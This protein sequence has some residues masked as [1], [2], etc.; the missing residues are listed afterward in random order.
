MAVTSRL[1]KLCRLSVDKRARPSQQ[2][3]VRGSWDRARL[4]ELQQA[5]SE[6]VWELSSRKIRPAGRCL[7]RCCKPHRIVAFIECLSLIASRLCLVV[8]SRDLML[9][10]ASRDQWPISWLRLAG[11]T[12][13][14]PTYESRAS[15]IIIY[16]PTMS[17]KSQRRP[18]ALTANNIHIASL[19][20]AHCLRDDIL[21]DYSTR[22]ERGKEVAWPSPGVP[23]VL[24]STN[25]RGTTNMNCA[26]VDNTPARA[27]VW[28][29]KPT[30]IDKMLGRVVTYTTC[31]RVKF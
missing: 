26:H 21:Q 24:A 28:E 29:G 11:E 16:H 1:C 25:V 13:K 22:N 20:P 23:F 27:M 30:L 18:R 7:S 19:G 12:T 31:R 17:K 4:H 9:C 10:P 2:L 8:G 5:K 3:R 14:Y 15:L 6:R